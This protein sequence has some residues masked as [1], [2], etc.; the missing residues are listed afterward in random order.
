MTFPNPQST[1]GGSNTSSTSQVVNMPAGVVAGDL[2]LVV[3]GFSGT[4]TV[5]LAGWSFLSADNNTVQLS[6]G[7][8]VSDGTEGASQTFT[9]G[10]A[11]LTVYN[12]YR[13]SGW[14]LIP[15]K[16]VAATGTSRFPNSPSLA[17]SWGAKDTLWIS[18][19]AQDFNEAI[20]VSPTNYTNT[21]SQTGG[22]TLCI[23]SAQRQ[24]NASSDDPSAWTVSS[25]K[26]WVAQTLAIA[27]AAESAFLPPLGS[28]TRSRPT[29]VG[30]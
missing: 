8:R 21:L 30:Y 16:G 22:V 27:P 20:S 7:Y 24:L 26:D 6:V 1:T 12:I 2:L 28:I 9:L 29:M 13:I 11:S 18:A 25:V 4:T 17:P 14:G 10:T 23:G 3:F 19:F 5:S 15:E